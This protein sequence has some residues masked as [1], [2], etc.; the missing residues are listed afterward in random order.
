[1]A[2]FNIDSWSQIEYGTGITL[3]FTIPREIMA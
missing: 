1:V 3:D 2:E